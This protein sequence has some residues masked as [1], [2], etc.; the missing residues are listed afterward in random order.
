MANRAAI[1]TGASR[2]IG[3][4]IAEMLGAEGY[5]LTI[6]AR[7]PESLA[8]TADEL[9]ARGFAVEHV[10]ANLSSPEAVEQ[11]VD[12]HRARFGRLDVLVNNAGIGIAGLADTH[13][14]KFIDMQVNVNFRTPVLFYKHGLELLKAAAAEH[15]SAVVVNIASI[16]GTV[17]APGLSLYGATKAAVIAYTRTMNLELGSVGIKSVALCPGW[18]DTAMADFIKD[19]VPADT[20]LPVSDVAE[21]VRFVLR[22][23]PNCVVP[24]II[25][26]RASDNGL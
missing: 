9:R 22:V 11:I 26:S 16:A 6:T 17:A 13:E 4:A 18:V 1:V 25:L 24:E 20:M 10:A 23:S 5:D 12:A 7:R 3:R 15:G 21:A 8:Q 14:L 2:G 19:Q